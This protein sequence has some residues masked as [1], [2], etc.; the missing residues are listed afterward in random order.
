M[1][2]AW[3]GLDQAVDWAEERAE[4]E[5]RRQDEKEQ[6]AFGLAAKYGVDLFGGE[7]T[8]LAGA[9]ST[10]EG[11]KQVAGSSYGLAL[12]TL[13][14][15]KRFGI[16]DEALAKI[17]AS[18]DKTAPGRLL[19]ILKK[20]Q[21]KYEADGRVMPTERVTE[22][23]ESAVIQQPTTKKIDFTKIEEYIGRP[24]DDLY[25]RILEQGATTA[26]LVDFADPA[27]MEQPTFAELDSALKYIATSQKD[28][29]MSEIA[30]LNR[31]IG[32]IKDQE[33]ITPT[34]QNTVALL[35][36]RKETV[37][38]ALDSF[39]DDPL[40]LVN[41]YGNSY[42]LKLQK[43]FPKYAGYLP[44]TLENPALAKMLVASPEIAF[45]MLKAGIIEEGTVIRLPDGTEHTVYDK[46]EQ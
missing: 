32:K 5:R 27:Y 34:Q 4:R 9:S 14:D 26:G 11:F 2:F 43:Q 16:S 35:V 1:A 18:G 17:V 13:Q 8:T 44:D 41:L 40:Q 23:I 38:K 36:Q 30:I 29:A 22:I 33:T 19:E 37:E 28:G 7:N 46:R 10:A 3:A 25:K 21:A 39:T 20:Q 42:A 15:P 24:L 12:K 31:A 6:F 45:A